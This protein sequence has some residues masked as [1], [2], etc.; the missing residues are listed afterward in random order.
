MGRSNKFNYSLIIPLFNEE[1]NIL[2]LAHKIKEVNLYK[3]GMSELILIDNGSKDNTKKNIQKLISTNTWIKGIFLKK[4]IHYGGA[5]EKGIKASKNDVV[6]IIPGYIQINPSYCNDC[7]NV[8]RKLSNN[9][10]KNI[11]LNGTRK[12]RNDSLSQKIVSI[13]FNLITSLILEIPQ[14]DINGLPKMFS[15]KLLKNLPKIFNKDFLFNTE[16]IL[17]AV[18]SSYK[19]IEIEVELEKRSFGESSWKRTKIKTYF[20]TLIKLLRIKKRHLN[21]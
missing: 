15:K 3:N 13:I 12:K 20:S 16:I 14:Y 11:F 7:A 1:Y 2:K 18:N 6:C 19:F 17:L 10:Y 8:Y 9:G 4:N 21:D 5:I